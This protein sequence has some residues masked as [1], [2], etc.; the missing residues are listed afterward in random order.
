MGIT[1]VL[2]ALHC[3]VWLKK[4]E[5]KKKVIPVLL[6]SSKYCFE[7]YLGSSILFIYLFPFET[8]KCGFGTSTRE[9]CH[10][11]VSSE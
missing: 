8:E 9:I 5:K 2:T 7:F 10:I 3:V 4:K 11:A 6:V 1:I